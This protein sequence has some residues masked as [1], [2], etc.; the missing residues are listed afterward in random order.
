MILYEKKNPI[1]TRLQNAIF[2]SLKLLAMAYHQCL[3]ASTTVLHQQWPF[4]R[5]IHFTRLFIPDK[6][7]KASFFTGSVKGPPRL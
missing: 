6:Q 2:C 7:V 5:A 1:C 3:V 4:T